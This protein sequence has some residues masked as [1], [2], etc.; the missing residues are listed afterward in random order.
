MVAGRVIVTIYAGIEAEVS[1]E[2]TLS[3]GLDSSTTFKVGAWWSGNWH[4]IAERATDFNTHGWTWNLDGTIGARAYIR[5]DIEVEFYGIVGPGLDLEPYVGFDGSVRMQTPGC[6]YEWDLRVGVASHANFRAGILDWDLVE[7]QATLFDWSRTIASDEGGLCAVDVYCL[8][9]STQG[10]GDVSLN[11][12]DGCYHEG[13][14]VRITAQAYDGWKFDHWEEDASG[15]V[16][17]TTITMNG[18]RSVLAIFEVENVCTTDA[19]CASGE[20]CVTGECE[21]VEDECTI[22][23]DCEPGEECA[24]GECVTIGVCQ[25]AGES[26]P[27]DYEQENG[28]SIIAHGAGACENTGTEPGPSFESFST[29]LPS[30]VSPAQ[31]MTFSVDWNR[32]SDCNPNAVIYSTFVGDWDLDTPLK[33]RG[34]YFTN[35]DQ[36]ARDEVT[37]TAPMQPGIY[38]VRWIMC[39]AFDAIRNFCGEAY[40][41][42]ASDPGTCPYI[43]QTFTVLGCGDGGG[44]EIIKQ[45]QVDTGGVAS[46]IALSPDETKLYVA[47]WEDENSSRVQ[48][49]SLPDLALLQTFTF[50]SYHTH[51]DV[52]VSGDGTRIFTTNYYYSSISQIDLANG[53]TRTDLSTVDSWPAGIS[54]TPDKTKVLATVGQDGRSYDMGNDSI[55]IYDISGGTFS[56]LASVVLQDESRGH[57]FGVSQ[58]SRFAYIAT[59][60]RQSSNPKLYEVSLEAPFEVT[61]TLDFPE[62]SYELVYTRSLG[63]RIYV[64]DPENSKIWVV[65]RTSWTK[66]GYALESA[67]TALEVHPSGAYLFAVMSDIGTVVAIDVTS[68]SIVAR[69]D[70]LSSAAHDIEFNNNG[71]QMYIA[72]RSSVGEIMVFDL[73]W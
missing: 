47:Y 38:R 57:S 28:M 46:G 54:M 63:N 44:L 58:D 55:A 2:G 22:D 40:T 13:T 6:P 51:G 48:E 24:G 21:P 66:T 8:T 1:A 34:G 30:T 43:E 70:G 32:C 17:T 59:R 61:R 15:T 41:G 20:E 45:T 33:V 68:M 14:Q 35:C 29:S 65:D 72:H 10:G 73:S 31:S 37:F 52:V 9:T 60:K 25:P 16:P 71:T 50:G 12:N 67:P 49:F 3:T 42:D 36:T 18:S 27:I 7:Y 11:P 64:S 4:P 5:P 26:C 56:L 19:D 69:Y 23:A 53:N 62:A 39:F